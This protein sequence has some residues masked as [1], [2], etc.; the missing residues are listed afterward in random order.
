MVNFIAPTVVCTAAASW[1]TILGYRNSTCGVVCLCCELKSI[2]PSRTPFSLLVTADKQPRLF[3]LGHLANVF[4]KEVM[5]VS[6]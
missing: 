4:S 1:N 3:R 6:G 2:F 5:V